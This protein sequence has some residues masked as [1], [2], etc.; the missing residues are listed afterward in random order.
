MLE[1]TLTPVDEQ[2]IRDLARTLQRAAGGERRV[3]VTVRAGRTAL[4]FLLSEP[5]DPLPL[6]GGPSTSDW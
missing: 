1:P 4:R 5:G 2:I 3:K 6:S